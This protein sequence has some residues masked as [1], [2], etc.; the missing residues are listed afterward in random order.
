MKNTSS[1]LDELKL[2]AS[3]GINGNDIIANDAF[4]NKYLVSLKDASY[5]LTGDGSTLAAGAY[6]T[7]STNPDLTWETTTQTNFGI[8]ASFLKSRLNV[9]LDYFYKKTKDMLVERPYI[10]VIGEGGYAWYNGGS[11]E[12][13]GIEGAVTWR[14][15]VKDFN[16]EASFNLSYYKNKV[17]KLSEDIY[18]TYGGGNGVDKTLVGQPF[19]SWF[20]FKTDGIFHSQ[21]EVD[22]YKSKYGVEFGAPGIGRIK[23]VDANGDGKINT[24]DRTWLGSDNPKFIGGLNLSCSYK[25]FDISMFFN[26]MIRD[27]YNNSKYYT[28]LF[29]CWT[30]NHSTRLLDAVQAYKDFETTGYYN[31]STPAVTTLNTNNE[32][33]VSEFYIEDG[34]Y[35]KMKSLTVGYTLPTSILNKLSLRSARVYLQAQNLFT[36]TGYTGADPEGLGYAYPLPRTFSFGVSFGF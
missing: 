4:Y 34:S 28:D 18:Y 9:S 30:G 15:H 31:C 8:D 16:Y 14:D 6:K 2:R 35:I 11:M 26:G 5:N 27:A 21:K 1:W 13:K 32:N 24:N 12:N 29:Q 17:T 36:I 25:G 19:G 7:R 23:Y 33:L 10:A 20:G 3:W 22:E